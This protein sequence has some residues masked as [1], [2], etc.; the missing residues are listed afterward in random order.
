[1]ARHGNKEIVTVAIEKSVHER[2]S[3]LQRR[4]SMQLDERVS[5][6]LT[7]ALLM[8]AYEGQQDGE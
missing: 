1:M 2:L 4:L 8:A 3:R 5:L 7:V 6:S